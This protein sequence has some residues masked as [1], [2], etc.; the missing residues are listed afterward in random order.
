MPSSLS[1]LP[2][3]LLPYQLSHSRILPAP[4]SLKLAP[5]WWLHARAPQRPPRLDGRARTPTP[6]NQPIILTNRA[7]APS[8]LPAWG[9]GGKSDLHACWARPF[10]RVGF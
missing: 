3:L 8:Y 1:L 6:D 5:P 10:M 9:L 2:F 4:G 7:R